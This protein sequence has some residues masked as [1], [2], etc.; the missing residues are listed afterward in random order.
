L[1]IGAEAASLPA[2]FGIESDCRITVV[3][4]RGLSERYRRAIAARGFSAETSNGEEA[5]L[6]G[7]QALIADGEASS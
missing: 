2:L 7:L 1:L 6:A 4:E 3:G 5:V